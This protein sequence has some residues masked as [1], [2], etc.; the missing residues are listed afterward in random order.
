MPFFH[1]TNPSG[2]ERQAEPDPERRANTER[3]CFE[4]FLPKAVENASAMAEKNEADEAMPACLGNEF[5][6]YIL[7]PT[8]AL[9]LRN[10]FAVL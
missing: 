5:S 1:H 6:E 8:L 9:T 7:K 4:S 3:L 2:I 10:R